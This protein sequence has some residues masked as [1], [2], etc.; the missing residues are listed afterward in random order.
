MAPPTKRTLEEGESLLEGVKAIVLDIEGTI[1]P[2]SFVKEKLFPYVTENI[3]SY[4]TTRYDEEE[5]QKD[6][7][8]LRDLA[9][10]DKEDG[11]DVVEIPAKTDDNKE[12]VVK[13][14]VD[15]VKALMDADSKT[16]ALKELQGHMWREAYKTKK[17]EGE[18]FEDVAPVLQ[19]LAEED[20]MLYIYSS[21]SVEAQKLLLAHSSDGDVTDMFT[22]F[23][24]TTSG[25]KTESSSYET[26]NK[27]ISEDVA[28]DEVTPGEILF[29]TDSPEEAKAA[30]GAKWQAVL[31]DRSMDQE[32][33]IEFTDEHRQTFMVI[34]NLND[35]FGEDDDDEEALRD[36]KRARMEGNGDFGGDDVEDDD[37]EGDDDEVEYDEEEEDGA[38]EDE[39]EEA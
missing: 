9:S 14:V 4:L 2:I 39:D 24:D 25:P 36:I 21:G 16:T 30:C 11:K 29:L 26:I 37:G 6:I 28:D 34:E 8:A 17:V 7:S 23:F 13:A 20:F 10:K 18:L 15:N 12:A 38:E 27:A 32:G 19:Q 3:E 5:T 22:G 35:L 31:V 1:A 33:G